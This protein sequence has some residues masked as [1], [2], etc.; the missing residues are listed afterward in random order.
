MK[1]TKKLLV[2]IAIVLI[3]PF[4]LSSCNNITVADFS[5]NDIGNI[6]AFLFADNDY[7]EYYASEYNNGYNNYDNGYEHEDITDN[8]LISLNTQYSPAVNI[9][10]NDNEYDD[11]SGENDVV[12]PTET[13]V[14]ADDDDATVI[15]EP[16]QQYVQDTVEESPPSPPAETAAQPAVSQQ[17]AS[18][19]RTT[20]LVRTY[21]L[22][23]D[24]SPTFE[25][26]AF[27]SNLRMTDAMKRNIRNLEPFTARSFRG[28][29][30]YIMTTQPLLFTPELGGGYLS[31]MRNYRTRLVETAT[32]ARIG[33][34]PAEMQNLSVEIEQQLNAGVHLA[35]ILSAPLSVQSRLAEKGLLTNLRRVPFINLNAPHYNQSAITAGTIN[36]NLYSI[37]SDALFDPSTIYAMFFNRDLINSHNLPNPAELHIN[38]IWTYDNMFE[39]G[40]KFAA[41]AVDLDATGHLLCFDK[42]SNAIINGLF[43]NAGDNFTFFDAHT[44]DYP[45]LNFNNAQTRRF[46]DSIATLFSQSELN[47]NIDTQREVFTQGNTLFSIATLDTIPSIAEA[48]FD[49]G[50]LPVPTTEEG[51]ISAT[52]SFVLP[53][54]LAF[55]VLRGT[56][57]TE[58]SGYITEALAVASHQILHETYL[59]EQLMYT[60]RD[61]HSARVLSDIVSNVVYSQYNMYSTIDAFHDATV[62]LIREAAAQ[63][64]MLP[65]DESETFDTFVNYLHGFARGR[66]NSFFSTSQPFMRN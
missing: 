64:M 31:D 56:T 1:N 34:V 65:Y 26:V 18:Q 9:S 41:S 33:V 59:R 36:G 32:G 28:T 23:A 27:P 21:T 4:N 11:D 55:S 10:N 14:E 63:R 52:R 47:Q 60:L 58:I 51:G 3:V 24:V 30:A 29:T 45:K 16:P 46:I 12:E 15:S 7:D 62:G 40:R 54:T 8:T 37:V 6:M 19:Q 61:I 38:G 43:T 50:I 66:L 2:L 44:H 53:D 57:N 42:E 13:E 22:F 20:A 35:D 39:L 5:P 48:G 17:Q 49:W 25:R